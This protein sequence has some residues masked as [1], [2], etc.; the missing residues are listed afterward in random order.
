MA[1]YQFGVGSSAVS[2]GGEDF[3][4]KLSVQVPPGLRTGPEIQRSGRE[5]VTPFRIDDLSGGI[6]AN[7]GVMNWERDKNLIFY[8]EGAYGVWIPG[9][10]ALPYAN[11]TNAAVTAVDHSGFRAANKR[12]HSIMSS[13]GASGQ[14]WYAAIGAQFFKDTST[15]DPAIT[16]PTTD[17]IVDV[18]TA[19]GPMRAG[20]TDYLAVAGEATTNVLG[21]P[22]PTVADLTVGDVILVDLSAGDYI[23]AIDFFPTMGPDGA[24]IVIGE[25]GGVNQTWFANGDEAAPFELK[26]VVLEETKAIP[27]PDNATVTIADKTATFGSTEFNSGSAGFATDGI[28]ANPG[29]ITASDDTYA[30][31]QVD[32]VGGVFMLTDHLIAGGFDLTAIP[33]SSEITGIE[34]E[35]EVD[36]TATNGYFA[37]VELLINGSQAGVNLGDGRAVSMTEQYF[38]FGGA[39]VMWGASGLTGQDIQSLAVRI[40][41]GSL[42]ATAETIS[43]DHVRVSV[44][45]RPK[46]GSP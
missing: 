38:S 19:I 27:N 5:G 44:T 15:T 17:G 14:R 2:F 29:N 21:F 4:L 28:W 37:T 8:S 18:I 35:A 22:D 46:G 12:V 1:T 9:I 32:A 43:V 26:P 6:F 42:S 11:T 45:Y 24:N 30:T 20:G 25:V 36:S 31:A 23:T 13:L 41:F 40:Q 10:F 7:S 3:P 33:F 16:V 39:T 34:A